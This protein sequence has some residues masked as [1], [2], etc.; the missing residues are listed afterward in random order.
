MKKTYRYLAAA[1]LALASPVNAQ[2]VDPPPTNPPAANPS[3][4]GVAPAPGVPPALMPNIVVTATG[5]PEKVSQIASTVQVIT[6]DRIAHSPAKSVSELL[7]ENAVGFMSQWTA[8]QTS[9]NIR[10]GATEGQGRDFKSQVL[11][12]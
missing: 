2:P 10:G 4:T 1:S 3:A 11:V 8:A 12:L 6:Q 9:I 7:A 5:Y